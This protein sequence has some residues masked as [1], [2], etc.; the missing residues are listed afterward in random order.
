M[1]VIVSYDV[2]VEKCQKLL[3]LLRKYLFH[4]HNSVFEGELTNREKG[5]LQLKISKIL[6]DDTSSVIFYCLP[7][8]KPL[9]KT[10]I[11]QKHD[12]SVII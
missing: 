8:Q 10:C 5:D 7:S 4:V 11:G 3:K 6:E 12:I 9:K 2:E 1:Y